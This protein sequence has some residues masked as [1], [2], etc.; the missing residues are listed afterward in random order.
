MSLWLINNFKSN[1]RGH[2]GKSIVSSAVVIISLIIKK[3]N[4]YFDLTRSWLVSSIA[5][6]NAH[7]LTI[8]P[9]IVISRS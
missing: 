4:D 7:G 8:T 5:S 3:I 6:G 2:V 9:W 1:E